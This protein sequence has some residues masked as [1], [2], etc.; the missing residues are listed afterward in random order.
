MA[1]KSKPKR[2]RTRH[3]VRE[4]REMLYP[5]Q[6]DAEEAL[7]WSQSKVSRLESGRT[8]YNQDD[9]EHAAEVFG[10]SPSD[11]LSG[12]PGQVA[13]ARLKSA[14]IAYGVDRDDIIQVMRAIIG[15]VVDDDGLS[16]SDQ[17]RDRFEPASPRREL[18]PSG[19]KSRP[20]SS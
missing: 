4:W 13:E 14:L 17:P 15:F 19:S 18:E 10:C 11:L 3:F 2:T 8:P 16:Q 5:N 7:G 12:P 6:V 1:P 20:P 9:L